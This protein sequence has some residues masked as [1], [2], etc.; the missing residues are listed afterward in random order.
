MSTHAH[1]EALEEQRQLPRLHFWQ[2]LYWRRVA[3]FINL[4]QMPH[5]DQRVRDNKKYDS[6]WYNMTPYENSIEAWKKAAIAMLA[7]CE[8][9]ISRD[10][11]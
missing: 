10:Q 2:R 6:N 5:A 7:A 8:L 11:S 3:R 9:E 4:V 1:E